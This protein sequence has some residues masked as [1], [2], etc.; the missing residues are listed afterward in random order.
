MRSLNNENKKIT[1]VRSTSGSLQGKN[2]DES[3][4][5]KCINGTFV[6][7]KTE[8]NIAF[9][10]RIKWMMVTTFVCCGLLFLAC[11]N[12]DNNAPDISALLLP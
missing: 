1:D 11:A 7:K 12:N 8:S 5:V 6:G 2:Y 3:L 4:A 9:K 10:G